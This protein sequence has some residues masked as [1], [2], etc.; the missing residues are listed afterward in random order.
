MIYATFKK[1]NDKIRTFSL[2]GH[3]ESGPYGHDL[4]CAAASALA[5]GTT[6]NLS[7]IAGVEPEIKADEDEGGFLEVVLPRELDEKQQEHV[8]ILLLS[9]YHSLMDVEE[10][11]GDFI[12]VSNN[13]KVK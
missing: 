10:S 1:E 13:G 12:S 11:Y 8:Q 2:S 7:R 5:I 3:A 9:L 6:N 4:V